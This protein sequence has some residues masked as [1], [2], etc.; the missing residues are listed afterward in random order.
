MLEICVEQPTS[1][2]KVK[3]LIPM[4]E[5]FKTETCTKS[6]KVIAEPNGLI[7]ILKGNK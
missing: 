7:R 1:E 4:Y 3:A 6:G 2:S 5:P